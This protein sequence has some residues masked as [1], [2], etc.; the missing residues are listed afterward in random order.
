MK[1]R[2]VPHAVS[3][4]CPGSDDSPTALKAAMVFLILSWDGL[5]D[6]PQLDLRSNIILYLHCC[7]LTLDSGFPLSAAVQHFMLSSFLFRQKL[8]VI[9]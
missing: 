7:Q 3:M 1:N 5:E 2:A 9:D 4:L 8:E 6:V